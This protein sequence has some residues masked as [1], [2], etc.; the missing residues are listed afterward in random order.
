MLRTDRILLLLERLK[1]DVVFQNDR[2]V[3][4]DKRGAGYSADPKIGPLE[5]AL[6]IMLQMAAEREG[7]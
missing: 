1:W 5:A 2:I 7:A 3:L 6:S 4:A